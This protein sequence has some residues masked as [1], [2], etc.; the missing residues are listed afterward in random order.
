[1]LTHWFQS[2]T[3][4]PQRRT[5]PVSFA[6]YL[7]AFRHVSKSSKK[8][9]KRNGTACSPCSRKN[10]IIKHSGFQVPRAGVTHNSTRRKPVFSEAC[11]V[12][13]LQSSWLLSQH[14]FHPT[15]GLSY[16]SLGRSNH[17]HQGQVIS[18]I[19]H[20]SSPLWAA[21]VF[22]NLCPWSGGVRT[23]PAAHSI[24]GE[25]QSKAMFSRESCPVLAES[26]QLSCGHMVSCSSIYGT[27]PGR[28]KSTDLTFVSSCKFSEVVS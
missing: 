6:G 12:S 11:M 24:L 19:L 15:A 10:N 23:V 3:P 2:S 14:F 5:Q 13:L 1:M 9:W 26:T 27:G 21:E 18:S 4:T 20:L 16:I 22:G 28:D 8:T 7:A 17:S 25:L